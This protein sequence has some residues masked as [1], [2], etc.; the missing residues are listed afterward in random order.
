MKTSHTI[1]PLSL[2][3]SL[4][5]ALVSAQFALAQ[6]PAAKRGSQAKMPLRM[7]PD[8]RVEQRSYHF[9]DTDEDLQLKRTQRKGC[10]DSI[11]NDAERIQN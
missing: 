8:P 9:K 7:D 11:G 2:I 5:I 6:P 4:L 1:C 10:N 3:L